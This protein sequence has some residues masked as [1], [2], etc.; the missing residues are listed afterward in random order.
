MSRVGMK[1]VPV[2]AGVDLQIDGRDV[3]VKG[4]K[5]ELAYTLPP[6]IAIERE[7]AEVALSR[8]NEEATTRALHGTARSVVANMVQGVQDG[9]RRELEIQGVGFRAQLQGRTLVLNVGYSHEIRYDGLEGVTIEH[10]A[11]TGLWVQGDVEALRQ[12]LANLITNAVSVAPEGS[13]IRLAAGSD[14]GWVWMAVE[15]RGPGI[16]PEEQERVFQ[17]FERGADADYEGTGLGL[18]IVRQIAEAH[19]GEVRLVSEVGRGSTFTIWIPELVTTDPSLQTTEM[20][21]I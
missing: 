16:P 12:A 7:G 18:T 15:D 4:P 2:P 13:S 21:R 14:T 11:P 10:A 9:Y 8:E 19:R 17:R 6:A 20:Q 5:G 3:R 1:P